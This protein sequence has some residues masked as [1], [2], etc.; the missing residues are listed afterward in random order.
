MEFWQ[1]IEADIKRGEMR[2]VDDE[3]VAMLERWYK[4]AGP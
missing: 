2:S 4:A 3:E 1:R